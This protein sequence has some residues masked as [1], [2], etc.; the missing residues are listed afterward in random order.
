MTLD[1]FYKTIENNK[2]DGCFVGFWTLYF[3]DTE[4]NLTFIG[5]FDHPKYETYN[6]KSDEENTFESIEDV[7]DKCII[8]G[9][10]LKEQIINLRTM[11]NSEARTQ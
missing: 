3:E 4:L 10:P 5:D 7:I 11:S 8:D 9:K 6:Y 2:I 1:E